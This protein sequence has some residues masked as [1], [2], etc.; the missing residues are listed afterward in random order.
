MLNL[1]T[2]FICAFLVTCFSLFV[3]DP[4]VT[5]LSLTQGTLATGLRSESLGSSNVTRNC[6]IRAVGKNKWTPIQKFPLS[7]LVS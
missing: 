2:L 7:N 5:N 3:S 6:K 4:Q 1:S